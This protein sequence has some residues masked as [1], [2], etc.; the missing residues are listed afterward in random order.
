M[1]TMQDLRFLCEE[2]K[3]LQ[4]QRDELAEKKATVEKQLQVLAQGKI[5]EMMEA[6]GLR[7]ATFEGLGRV[8][9][10]EDIFANTVAGKK[11]EG[12]QWL[13][14]CGYEDMIQEDFNMSSAKALF[15][16]MIREGVPIPNEI[17]NITPYTRASIVK[18]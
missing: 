4:A 17:F 13:R 5:P 16:R 6:L 1:S 12:I 8:Q 14:D 15:R 2:M 10:A 18:A 11:P 3:A 9:L 7:N